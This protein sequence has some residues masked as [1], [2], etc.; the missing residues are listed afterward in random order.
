MTFDR[1][2]ARCAVLNIAAEEATEEDVQA[3][4]NDLAACFAPVDG[5]TLTAEERDAITY[6]SNYTDP[7]SQHGRVL[8]VLAARLAR[9]AG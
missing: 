2:K 9:E 1:D 5:V 4:L 3:T 6:A 8:R 7:A